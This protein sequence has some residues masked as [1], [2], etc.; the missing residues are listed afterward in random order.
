MTAR[1]DSALLSV[2]EA[3]RESNK[4]DTETRGESEE[5]VRRE[6]PT[7]NQRGERREGTRL[8]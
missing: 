1:R 4:I 3:W 5:R 8:S 2:M 7:H 6:R